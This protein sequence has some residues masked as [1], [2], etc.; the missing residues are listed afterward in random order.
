MCEFKWPTFDIGWPSEGTLDLPTFRAVY[1]VITGTP[2]H[3][4][5]FPY[6]DSW[7]LIAKNLPPWVWFCTNGE[8]QSK[9][10]WPSS[11]KGRRMERSSPS[12]QEILKMTPDA[13]TI[14][15]SGTTSSSIAPTSSPAGQHP[16]SVS[17]GTTSPEPR[18]DGEAVLFIPATCSV[19]CRTPNVSVGNIEPR[20]K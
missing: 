15:P 20:S 2:G 18:A 19:D 7:L 11:R 16:P 14:A 5:Q 17:S 13:P 8:G 9:F 4:N 10:P 1:Q 12:S 3:P 6:I